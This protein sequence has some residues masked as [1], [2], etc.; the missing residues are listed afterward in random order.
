MKDK[1]KRKAELKKIASPKQ[2][3]ILKFI[4]DECDVKFKGTSK[5]V[6]N[7][8]GKWYPRALKMAEMEKAIGQ[9]GVTVYRARKNIS[10]K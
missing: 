1:K 5:E 9:L 7:F 6:Y 8:I 3:K 4:K 10:W 2:I